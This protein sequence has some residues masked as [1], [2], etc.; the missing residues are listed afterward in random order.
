MGA[1]AVAALLVAWPTVKAIKADWE[2]EQAARSTAARKNTQEYARAREDIGLSNPF[3]PKAMLEKQEAESRRLGGGQ[4]VFEG[5]ISSLGPTYMDVE[6]RHY[7]TERCRNAVRG[8]SHH[9]EVRIM[10]NGRSAHRREAWRL[11]GGG[12]NHIKAVLG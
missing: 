11:C 1:T 10:V 5:A 7:G 8:L 3:P 12:L 2:A 9:K 4:H 6:F